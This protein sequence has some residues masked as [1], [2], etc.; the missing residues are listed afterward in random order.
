MKILIVLFA[1]LLSNCALVYSQEKVEQEYRIELSQV[2]NEA[3]QF[4][5]AFAPESK[6]K[7]LQEESA[8]GTTVEAKFK[9]NGKRHSIEFATSGT[10]EDVE[11]VIA[12][13]EIPQNTRSLIEHYFQETFD[14][15]KIE[16]VQAQYL[17]S[18]DEILDWQKGT[19]KL[20]PQ[21]EIVL[22]TR[23]KAVK[24][25]R[26]QLLFDYNGKLVEKSRVTMRRDNIL[27]F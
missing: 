15:F 14:Y 20:F 6:I 2:P 19:K 18:T 27:R 12:F 7:W 11:I 4:I 23:A 5:N 21:Y 24:A 3:Q 17:G 8:K 13:L 1:L 22:K 16:K 9:L 26:F 10:L 25:K